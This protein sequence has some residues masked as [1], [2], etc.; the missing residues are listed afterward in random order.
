M[1]K[2]LSLAAAMGAVGSLVACD[3]LGQAMTSHTDVVARAAGHEF[4]VDQAVELLARNPRVP[5]QPEV[6]DAIANL[7]VDYTLFA[8]AA[9]E[10]SSLSNIDLEPLLTPWFNQELVWGLREKVIQVDTVISD[11]VLLAEFERRQPN[12]QVRARHILFRLPPNGTAE[13]RDSVIA[14]A[15]QV[16]EQAVTGTDFA[17]L[18][19]E[20]SED[21]GSAAQGGDLG[22]FGRG[23]MVGP[24]EDAAFALQV[25]QISE[26]IETPYGFHIIKVEEK[27]LPDFESNR[28]GFRRELVEDRRAEA[29][30]MY[31][32]KLTDSLHV[33]IA[34]GAISVAKDLAGKPGDELNRRAA[35]RPLATYTGGAFTAGEYLDFI[36]GLPSN[37]RSRLTSAQDEEISNLLEFYARNEIL[38]AEAAKQGVTTDSV[39]ADSMRTTARTQLRAAAAAAGLLDI[40]RQ[41]GESLE[42]AIDRKVLGFLQ[43]I[44]NGEQNVFS[45][46]PLS[47][48]LR[49]RYDG[50]V[51]ERSFPIVLQRVEEARPAE[52]QAPIPTQPQPQLPAPDTSAPQP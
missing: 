17:Q 50:E 52:S 2:L 48:A 27:A 15:R 28:E 22:M 1:R 9:A 19:R 10:D 32:Q 7:W 21:P 25:G 35:A 37:Q 3:A 43:G 26:L 16:R 42:Q 18:A 4:S 12:A 13:Q 51:Y 5:A 23:Q 44:L 34:D 49:S 11:S 30:E 36:R 40:Q 47:Y 45:L 38:V 46:G 20:H 33:E 29:E 24:F 6:I 41:E 31:V 14:V 8:Q 39:Q